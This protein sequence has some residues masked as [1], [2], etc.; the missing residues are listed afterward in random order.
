[1]QAVFVERTVSKKV[2]YRA[3][4]GFLAKGIRADLLACTEI[5]FVLG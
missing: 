3:L 2:K 5:G 1:M 4:R